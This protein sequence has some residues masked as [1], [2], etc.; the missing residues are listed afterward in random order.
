MK[1]EKTDS[2]KLIDKTKNENDMKQSFYYVAYVDILGYKDYFQSSSN[3]TESFLLTIEEAIQ[4]TFDQIESYYP[5]KKRSSEYSIEPQIR[6][7]SDNILICTKCKQKNADN[8]IP[9][10]RLV[11]LMAN[12]QLM[13][14]NNYQLIVRGS[15]VKGKFYINDRFVFGEAII[16]AYEMESKK[17]V[18]PRIILHKEEVDKIIK[19]INENDDGISDV[20]LEIEKLKALTTI[21]IGKEKDGSYFA[22]YLPAYN[23]RYINES[24]FTVAEVF[25]DNTAEDKYTSNSVV[26][27]HYDKEVE[28]KLKAHKQSI[29][30]KI[31]DDCNYKSNEKIDDEKKIELRKSIINKYLWIID[32]HNRACQ[33]TRMDKLK[34]EPKICINSLLHQLYIETEA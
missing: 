19:Y 6:I 30:K 33:M 1:N 16:D 3:D 8:Y 15:I 24:S 7:F 11:K 5:I 29:T 25:T 20:K 12:L 27:L 2:S 31:N 17:A 34:I 4:E 23:T 18:F 10:L 21:S 28:D 26:P 22:Q 32:Y 9:F 14:I 13:F